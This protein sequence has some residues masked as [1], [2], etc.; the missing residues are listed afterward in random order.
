MRQNLPVNQTSGVPVSS[1]LE[2]AIV[3]SALWAAAGDA[4]GWITELADSRAVRRRAGAETV[5]EPVEWKRKVGGISGAQVVLP[6][7]TYSDDTQLRLA[8]S[9]AIRADGT[10]D[11]E[12]F[13]K[14]ELTVWP[15]YAL[16]AGRGSKAAAANLAKRDVNW[17]SNFFSSG[18]G[19]TYIEGGG[20]GAAM[21][22]QPHV[23]KWAAGTAREYLSDVIRDSLTTHGH[24]LG[25]C[26]A[27]FHADCLSFA[28]RNRE[29]PGPEEWMRFVDGWADIEAVINED[30]QLGRFWLSAWEQASNVKLR[31][32]I[33]S[34]SKETRQYILKLRELSPNWG[35]TYSECLKVVDG[36]GSRQGAG[37]NTALAAAF[38]GWTGQ[39][40]STADVLRCAANTLGSDTDTIGT[41]VGAMLGAV[42]QEEP[43]WHIQDRDYIASQARRMAVLARGEGDSSFTYPDLIDWQ[44][45]ATQSDAVAEVKG[46]PALAGLGYLDSRGSSWKSGDFA[47]EWFALEF[48]QTVLCKRR[49]KALK[50]MDEKLIPP[51]TMVGAVSTSLI[52]KDTSSFERSATFAKDERVL[53][54]RQPHIQNRS[55]S[56]RTAAHARPTRDLFDEVAPPSAKQPQPRLA[57][58][59][60]ANAPPEQ[61]LPDDLDA[62][63]DVAIRS[64]FDPDVIGQC[65]LKCIDAQGGVE[66]GIAFSSIV[67]KAF[68]ARKRRRS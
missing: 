61:T 43:S 54:E 64:G 32:A 51:V 55:P 4:L 10:F 14:V 26:G 59:D 21:R 63:T 13:A 22:I 50:P 27:V 37:T 24:M 33:E 39:E 15:A 44:P 53:P 17:F 42:S 20:N 68:L 52:A 62:L 41:M 7:G 40:A 28:L 47:Y 6:A 5:H 9:R 19:R 23:W 34:V 48:G 12:L 56:Q 8:V 18:D 60:L 36:F 29:V 46:R 58:Q 2:S 3:N 1:V 65:L 45:P 16:G 25:V 30:Y 31:A 11:V 66:R 67:A 35:R 38:L 49:A 57:E